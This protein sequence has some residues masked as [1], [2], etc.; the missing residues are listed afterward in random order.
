MDRDPTPFLHRLGQPAPWPADAAPA[1]LGAKAAGLDAMLRSG[2]P[3]PPGS[4]LTTA[5]WHHHAV[6]GWTPSLG[7]AAQAAVRHVEAVSRRRLGAARGPLLVS[8]RSGGVVSMPGALSTVLDVGITPDA[9]AGLAAETGDAAFAWD[10]CGRALAGWGHIVLDR[11]PGPVLRSAPTAVGE[12]DL[13][14]H[15]AALLDAARAAGWDLPAEPLRQVEAAVEAVFRSWTSATA[16]AFRRLEEVGD[17]TGTA[18]TIQPMVYGNRSGS[19][20]GVAFSRDP[21]TGE[22]GLTGDLLPEAQGDDVVSGV[23]TT[24]PLGEMADLWPEA[25]R[26]LRTAVDGL[27]RHQADLVDVEF[28]VEDGRLWLLQ[29][30]PGRRSGRAA[31]R[32][33][34]DLAN[35][36]AFL[37]DRT[38]AVRRCRHLL[39]HP[40][41]EAV[42]ADP[43]GDA[44]ASGVGVSPGRAAGH[45][46]TDGA[47]AIARADAGEDVILVRP[48][49]S[50]DDLPALARCRGVV[51]AVGGRVCHAAIV[52]RS[53]GIPAV[54]GVTGLRV[55]TEGITLPSGTTLPAG[56][57]VTIDGDQGLLWRGRGAVAVPVPVPEVEILRTWADELDREPT[58]SRTEVPVD[59]GPSPEA[60]QDQVL[61]LLGRR[62][63]TPDAALA[64]ALDLDPGQASTVVAD[65]VGAGLVTGDPPGWSR[66]TQRGAERARRAEEALVQRADLVA[67]QVLEAFEGVDRRAKEVLSAT[68]LALGEGR[69]D[70]AGA[71]VADLQAISRR[72]GEVLA[73][74]AGEV[75]RVRSYPARLARATGRLADGDVRYLAHP[76]LDSFHTVWFEMH[77]DMIRLAGRTRA[78]ELGG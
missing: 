8:V 33:A 78:D 57:V 1:V 54:V 15:T 16:T 31:M 48:T 74:L 64:E 21:S 7:R 22:R 42:D 10:T 32:I 24:R 69:P 63:P 45:L 34:V 14:A 39:D 70:G 53:W 26:A 4:T 40:P 52:A 3:V 47:E 9:V 44:A 27:E 12:R 29:A 28:T 56:D 49:T 58:T 61:D 50:P 25:W 20:T 13:R 73:P 36:P 41:T 2:L 19:G 51:T 17:G 75:P 38:E 67:G 30:R 5:A 72:A 43:P 55:E 6:H 11:D 35:D 76:L 71:A 59:E 46:V 23:R 77:E 62:G 37:V 66:L 60:V 65:L 68:Q 18:A